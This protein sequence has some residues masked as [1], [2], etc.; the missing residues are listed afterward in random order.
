MT[1]T[2]AAVIIAMVFL[3]GIFVCAAS[4]LHWYELR[5]QRRIEEAIRVLEER[6]HIVQMIT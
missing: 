1:P 5:G 6:A 3:F 4:C 2:L